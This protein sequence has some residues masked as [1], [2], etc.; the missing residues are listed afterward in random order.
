MS[1]KRRQ[2]KGT[3]TGDN[4]SWTPYILFPCF[5]IF[6]ITDTYTPSATFHDMGLSLLLMIPIFYIPSCTLLYLY[7]YILT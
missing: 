2:E 5:S 4:S 1:I 6:N 7:M 3:G